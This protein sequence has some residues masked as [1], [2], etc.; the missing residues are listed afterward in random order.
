VDRKDWLSDDVAY[1][2]IRW[3]C[4]APCILKNGFD[5]HPS[6]PP[7]DVVVAVPPFSPLAEGPAIRA[8][9]ISRDLGPFNLPGMSP[10]APLSVVAR[11]P[12]AA[13]Q[14]GSLVVAWW[15]RQTD[16]GLNIL[17]SGGYLTSPTGK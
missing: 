16:D 6:T 7:D 8:M 9:S 5:L 14:P 2:A 15:T 13:L 17:Y 11:F 12:V 10:L 3:P 1:V 4:H